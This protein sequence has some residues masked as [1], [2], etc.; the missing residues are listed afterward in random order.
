M[1]RS[2]FTT[3]E[4]AYKT[5]KIGGKHISLQTITSSGTPLTTFDGK[6][7]SIHQNSTNIVGGNSITANNKKHQIIRANDG[8]N[9][10][11]SGNANTSVKFTTSSSENKQFALPFI[12][13]NG[14]LNSCSSGVTV[15]R[16]TIYIKREAPKKTIRSVTTEL[17]EK[18]PYVHLGVSAER[19]GILKNVVCTTA[20]VPVI[21]LYLTLKKIRQN[22]D[23][24]LLAEYFEFS[25]SEVQQ[26]FTRTI[27][28]LAR[29]LK[30][31]IRWPE[32]KK[33]YDRHKNLPIAFR[34]KLSYVQSL[35][36]CVETEIQ[37]PTMY[38]SVE[39]LDCS[40]Y[41]FILTITPTGVISYVSDAYVGHNDDL[42]IFNACDF[43]NV[44]PKY[45]SLVA[46]PGKAIRRRSK[47]V[48][49]CIGEA[50]SS[51]KPVK[52]KQRNRST[53]LNA[54]TINLQESDST[55]DSADESDDGDDQSTLNGTVGGG[56]SGS[57]GCMSRSNQHSTSNSH[58]TLN[59]V[60]SELI[61]R[62]VKDFR[63]PT[64]RV[65][66][67]VCRLQIRHMLYCLK[68]FRVLQPYA[69]L[70]PLLYQYINEV[71]IVVSA[72]T[73]LQR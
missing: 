54:L 72:L 30:F 23:F 65:R 38:P 67:S 45:L 49:P 11:S 15:R 1:K 69:I 57:T 18:N 48:K 60:N 70:E 12:Q 42:T 29:Y 71:L 33:Y 52:D 6:L 8:S 34:S 46:D 41:K 64:V 44:I 43:Q 47:K 63:I 56:I 26:I 68:E 20:N 3:V 50:A 37:A 73:N 25:E 59:I 9:I 2:S 39:Q 28:K 61:S 40:N 55:T 36:E 13:S 19:L 21:D 5:A 62:K 35:I 51:E 32:S 31:L 4:P 14:V 7:Y 53:K 16:P 10:L 58:Q 24:S 17:I 22:E 27:V 66:E